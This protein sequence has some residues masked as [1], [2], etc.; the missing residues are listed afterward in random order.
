MV[1]SSAH[2][3]SYWKTILL[4]CLLLTVSVGLV[5]ATAVFLD[6]AMFWSLCLPFGLVASFA[7]VVILGGGLVLYRDYRESTGQSDLF[8]TWTNRPAK[9]RSWVVRQL[10]NLLSPGTGRGLL[11][12]DLVQ[13]LPE[14]EIRRTLDADGALDGLPFMPEMLRYCGAQFRVFRWADKINDMNTKTGVRRLRDTVLL[15]GLRCDGSSHDGCQAGCQILWKLAWLQKIPK[16]THPVSARADA[17]FHGKA[18]LSGGACVG[19]RTKNSTDSSIYFCQMTE[20]LRASKPMKWWDVRQ[21]LR[22]VLYGNVGPLAFFLA[23]LT[24]LFNVVQALRRGCEYPFRPSSHLTSTP[25]EVL[26]LKSGDRVL[27]K[28]KEA[29]TQ[30]LDAH[31]RNRG[32]RYDREMIRYCGRRFV[33]QHSVTRLITED[34]ARMVTMK[35]P[36]IIL[37]GV[38]ST[39]EFLRF[40]PQNEYVLFREIWLER[41]N[42]VVE[43]TSDL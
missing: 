30:T 15:E 18:E 11:V 10:L 5:A 37:E 28:S 1:S 32:L 19:L 23:L 27:V 17:F 33:V 26:G 29:I 35:A 31:D 25:N 14:A 36:C 42:S 13:V 40:C 8:Y 6:G 2:R 9:A 3:M 24:R 41:D 12:G 34:S 22:S 21:D 4:A 16:V 7:S 39:G 38:T 43:T 20:L